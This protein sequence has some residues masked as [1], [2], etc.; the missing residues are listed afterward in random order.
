[1]CSEIIL[2]AEIFNNS[3]CNKST[4]KVS[5]EKIF[6]RDFYVKIHLYSLDDS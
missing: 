2:Y 6:E 4:K 5:P 1:M 3:Y